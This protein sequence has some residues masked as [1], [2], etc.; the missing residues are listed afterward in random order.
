M[1]IDLPHAF[2]GRFAVLVPLLA[3]FFEV[4]AV[5]T[6]KK[7]VEKFSGYLVI[8]A[9]ILVILAGLTGVQEYLYLLKQ[10]LNY[11]F[12]LHEYLGTVIVFSFSLIMFLRLYLLRKEN[13]KIATFY[14]FFYV[15]V[16]MINLFSNE[17]VVHTL[18]GN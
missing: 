9:S 3:L 6:Q 18:R 7:F 14:I 8:F 17:I 15:I 5:I 10:N 11:K 16:V 4:A 1:E 2:F 13:V 12:T